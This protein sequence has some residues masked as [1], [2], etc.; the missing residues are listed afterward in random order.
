VTHGK[1]KQLVL[2]A[3]GGTGGHIYP[4]LAIADALVTSGFDKDQIHFMGSKRALE[5]RVVP[6]A[7]YRITLLPGR[8]IKR[9]LAID[10]A[11]AV[12]GLCVALVRALIW[13]RRHKP[14]AVVSV[15]GYAAAPAAISAA[16]LGVPLIVAEA[17][18]I[19]G[20]VHRLVARRAAACAIAFPGTD[21]PR[22]VVTGNPVR[23]EL[24]GLDRSQPAQLQAR[25]ALGIDPHRFLVASFGGSLGARS[26]NRAIS[27]LVELSV[28]RHDLAIYH[29]V[30]RRDWQDAALR[31]S[32]PAGS[33]LT[34]RA[35]EYE[36]HMELL[37]SA[38]DVVI[39]RSG[40]TTTAELAAVGV[41][42]I[43]IPFPGAS[44]DHQTENAKAL[45]AAGAATVISDAACNGKSLAAAIEPLISHKSSTA[46]MAAA[47]TTLAVPDAADRVAKLVVEHGR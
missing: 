1:D 32:V 23:P 3:G 40:A 45:S 8:G 18:A 4:A 27:E 42:S 37:Y 19:P 36:N 35:V 9:S 47:A 15:G 28:D 46:K 29:V 21:L 22:A 6:E 16:L 34:Y 2:I 13:V 20:A 12:A 11:V 5:A 24:I 14:S 7:G 38:A 26:I 10:N 41:A 43:L 44:E 17:N 25:E 39:C 31:G 30:G 33:A